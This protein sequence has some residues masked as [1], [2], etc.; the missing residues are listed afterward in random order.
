ML[1]TEKI[2]ERMGKLKINQ[3]ELA[4]RIDKNGNKMSRQAISKMLQ[5]GKAKW[6]TLDSLAKALECKSQDLIM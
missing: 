6:E 4:R 3:S 5:T 2:K 1:N